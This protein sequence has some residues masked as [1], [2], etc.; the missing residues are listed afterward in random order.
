MSATEIYCPKCRWKP[1]AYDLWV[2]TPEIGGCGHVW[3]TFSTHGNCP[4]CSWQWLIT[5]CHSCR[6][7]SP[8]EHWYHDPAG[9][10]RDA[11]R[12]PAILEDA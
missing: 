7:F 10:P 1:Q 6:Q 4:K 12:V 3:N 11:A 5:S 2:C 8:H 9:K